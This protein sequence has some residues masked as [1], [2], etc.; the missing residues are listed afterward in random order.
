MSE[1]ELQPLARLGIMARAAIYRGV[2]LQ[3]TQGLPQYEMWY[4]GFDLGRLDNQ[5]VVHKAIYLLELALIEPSIRLMFEWDLRGPY[6]GLLADN[7]GEVRGL[8]MAGYADRLPRCDERSM[9]RVNENIKVILNVVDERPCGLEP[10]EWLELLAS[11]AFAGMGT[12]SECLAVIDG[13]TPLFASRS[14]EQWA[15]EAWHAL[16][17]NGWRTP[18]PTDDEG[19]HDEIE[20]D[21]DKDDIDPDEDAC[22]AF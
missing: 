3:E 14:S 12:L 17:E 7:L 18:N 21:G 4:D 13:R 15:K 5:V 22:S 9:E 8:I 10:Y 19:D 2:F 1:T 20:Y 11:L 16:E 6:S